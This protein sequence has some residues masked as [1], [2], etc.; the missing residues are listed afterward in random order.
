M[1][2]TP[3]SETTYPDHRNYVLLNCHV[4]HSGFFLNLSLGVLFMFGS[5]WYA[6]KTR[7]FPRNFNESKYIGISLYVICIC[8][9][10]FIPS[11]FV[12]KPSD[13]FVREYMISCLCIMVGFTLLSGLFIPKVKR[14]LN[15]LTES[16]NNVSIE[17]PSSTF[18]HTLSLS[19]KQD[20]SLPGSSCHW[21]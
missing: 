5:T 19:A 21:D 9:A 11:I 2:S 15:S 8:W 12:V 16:K 13:E 3:H 4:D 18:N 20:T 10:L 17:N 14:L 1:K 7:N 6:F